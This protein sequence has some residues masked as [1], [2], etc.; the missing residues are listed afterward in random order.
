M[1]EI[2]DRFGKIIISEVRDRTISQFNMI[3]DGSMKGL[4]AKRVRNEISGFSEDELNIL[5]GLIVDAVDY[6]LHNLCVQ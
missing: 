4:T 3:I 5:K 1:S 6:S 2:L